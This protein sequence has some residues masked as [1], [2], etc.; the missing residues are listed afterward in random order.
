MTM[1]NITMS[2]WSNLRRTAL[3]LLGASAAAT[4]GVLLGTAS[5]AAAADQTIDLYAVP[6]STT[7]PNGTTVDVLG[8][9]TT[10]APVDKPGGPVIVVNQGDLVTITLHNELGT[11]AD[12]SLLIK[13]QPLVPD[14]VG[15]ADAGT[16]TYTFTADEPGTF[17]YEAGLLPNTEY[18]TAMG[19]HGAFVVQPTSAPD[20]PIANQA[21][22]DA[23]TSYAA[24]SVLV[25]SELDPNLN[26]AA[27]PAAFDMRNYKPRFFL[28]DGKAHPQIDTISAPADADVLLRY[29]NAGVTNHS[30]G[31]LGASGQT[32]IA[33]DGFPLNDARTYVAE[34]I[35]PGQTLDALVHTP[36][37]G[38][39]DQRLSVYDAGMRLRN[40]NAD[41]LGGMLA[42]LQ[43]DG[44]APG[45]D[46]QGPV[47]SGAAWLADTLTA[48]VSDA[49]RGGHAITE[50]RAYFD[51]LPTAPIGLAAADG[52]FDS[53]DEDVTGSVP[54][55]SGEHTIYVQGFDGTTWGPLT[56]VLVTGADAGGP[57]VVGPVVNPDVTRQAAPKDVTVTATGDDSAS[58]NSQVTAAQYSIGTSAGDGGWV[59]MDVTNPAPVAELTGTIPTTVLD[60]LTEGSH[61]VWVRAQDAQGNWGDAVSVNLDVDLSAPAVGPVVVEKSPNNGLIPLTSSQPVVRVS[62]QQISDVAAGYTGT[63]AKVEMYVD[64]NPDTVVAP[65]TAFAIPMT[66]LDG[67]FNEQAEAPT[68]TSRSRRCGRWARATTPSTSGPATAPATG[69]PMPPAPWWW[70]PTTRSSTR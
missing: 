65:A 31:V 38:P 23:S 41:G 60:T 53:A 39:V 37:T 15:A 45:T 29:V 22:G 8:Y 33:M 3:G 48:H 67:L 6:G 43:V 70:T 47:S 10:N 9:N 32:V 28:V 54:V 4:L 50:A 46:D 27:D 63:I 35:G 20:V 1:R 58:G 24:A 44:V 14:L 25:L 5:P 12:T 68:A 51:D 18:Q 52:T 59:D 7:L 66:S 17:L 2:R 61:P 34:T 69:A 11:G 49:N 36:A 13:G 64:E 16:A 62:V 30:M 55:V 40:A 19:L 21:Y 57:T 26:N 56:S 42:T